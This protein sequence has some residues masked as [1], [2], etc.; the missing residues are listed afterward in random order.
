MSGLDDL[1]GSD[2]EGELQPKAAA[3]KP[4]SNADKMSK[5]QALAAAKRKQAVRACRRH[6]GPGGAGM[7][8]AT[9]TAAAAAC[10]RCRLLLLLCL[11]WFNKRTVAG[12]VQVLGVYRS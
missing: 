3:P 11:A 5:L 10:A 7:L 1:F 4:T 12:L 2:D 6:S 9:A 8:V